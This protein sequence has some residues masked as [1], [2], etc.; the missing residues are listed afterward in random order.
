LS[1]YSLVPQVILKVILE[2]K[3]AE[4]ENSR[5]TS[6]PI[7]DCLL[8]KPGRTI[9]SLSWKELRDLPVQ[10]PTNIKKFSKMSCSDPTFEN[11]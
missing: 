1:K 10:I 4:K 3:Y 2:L 6:K 7:Y 11:I 9:A 5:Y 8:L